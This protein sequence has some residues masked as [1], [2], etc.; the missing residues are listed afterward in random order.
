M[1]VLQALVY[2]TLHTQHELSESLQHDLPGRHFRE[3]IE[4]AKKIEEK[5]KP[6]K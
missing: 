3:A 4:E 2:C 1:M 5:L 6:P